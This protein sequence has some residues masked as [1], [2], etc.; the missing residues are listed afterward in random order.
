MT[1]EQAQ[2]NLTTHFAPWV[3]ALGLQV[4]R[5]GPMP[6]AFVELCLPYDPDWVHVGGVVCGQTL[7][8]AA[9]TA[10]VLAFSAA[11]GGFKPMTTVQLNTTFMRPVA[12]QD[13]IILGRVQRVGRTLG[14]AEI[15]IRA[16]DREDVAVQVTTTYA[17]LG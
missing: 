7:M 11:L 12:N 15:S 2:Q 1:L 8:A 17:W 13:A 16:A 9:D 3:R 6:E 14:F 10:A 5:I 4:M